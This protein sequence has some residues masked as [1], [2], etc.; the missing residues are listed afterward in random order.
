MNTKDGNERGIKGKVMESHSKCMSYR[1][2]FLLFFFFEKSKL[3]LPQPSSI[4]WIKMNS[5]YCNRKT[6]FGINL[7]LLWVCVCALNTWEEFKTIPSE[8]SSWIPLFFLL[9][10]L[11]HTHYTILMTFSKNFTVRMKSFTFQP[12][13]WKIFFPLFPFGYSFYHSLV[14]YTGSDMWVCLCMVVWI[15]WFA[16]EERT[17]QEKN[18][19]V[20]PYEQTPA[21]K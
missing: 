11:F 12:I 2:D 20:R 18:E 16:N 17:A 3:F 8:F 6:W 14:I 21:C 5:P 13:F 7:F 10:V 19:N 1:N 4:Q 15:S 9:L